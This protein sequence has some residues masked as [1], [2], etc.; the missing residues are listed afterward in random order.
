MPIVIKANTS[1]KGLVTSAGWSGYLIPGHELI[2][3]ADATV[4]AKLRAAGAII[5]G[6]TNMPDFAAGDTTISSGLRPHGQATIPASA[7]AGHRAGRSPRSRR[8]SATSEP[9]RTR[10]TPSGCRRGRARWWAFLPTRGLISIAGIH[11]LNW[12]LDDTGPIA[13]DV[14]DAAI[15]LDVMGGEDPRDFRD[16]GGSAAQAEPGPY[17]KFCDAGALEGEA[18]W[19]AGVHGQGGDGEAIRGRTASRCGQKRAHCS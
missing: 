9:G 8:T 15:A 16:E 3:P 17:A 2:A 18:I 13:R 1:V 4:V 19:R 11:P 10:A 6:Q 5:V 12:L 7:P 14:T